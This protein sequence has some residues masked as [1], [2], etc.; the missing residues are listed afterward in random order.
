MILVSISA[1]ALLM[2]CKNSPQLAKDGAEKH[3]NLSEL[4]S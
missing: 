1:F 2:C 3:R 4:K